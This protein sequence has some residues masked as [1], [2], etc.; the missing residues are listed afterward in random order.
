MATAT[1]TAKET[2]NLISKKKQ[3]YISFSLL[4]HRETSSLHVLWKN[5][6]MC[7]Q[8]NFVACIPFCFIS[9]A[10]L[11]SPCWLLAFLIFSPPLQNVNVAPPTKFVNFV[12]FI[13]CSSFMSPFFLLS[14]A[15]LSRSFSFSLS[16]S[17]SI[18]QI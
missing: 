5:C 3:L 12:F 18:F 16:F 11:F 7:S 1:R 13:A 8:K 4:L 10:A 14:F 2:I 6:C 17:F 15:S 9:S